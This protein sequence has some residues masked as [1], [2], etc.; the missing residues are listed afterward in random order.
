MQ[1][2]TAA[3]RSLA[4][5]GW[6]ATLSCAAAQSSLPTVYCDIRRQSWRGGGER[7]KNPPGS[8]GLPGPPPRICTSPGGFADLTSGAFTPLVVQYFF[9]HHPHPILVA[10]PDTV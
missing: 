8:V 7:G 6:N 5:F 2:F 3:P 4:M 1:T 9:P 10:G